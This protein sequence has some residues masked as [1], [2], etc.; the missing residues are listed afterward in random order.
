MPATGTGRRGHSECAQNKATKESA[1]SA[2]TAIHQ[3]ILVFLQLGPVVFDVPR[4]ILDVRSHDSDVSPAEVLVVNMI[5][6]IIAQHFTP[7]GKGLIRFVPIHHHPQIPSTEILESGIKFT[8][9]IGFFVMMVSLNRVHGLGGIDFFRWI[10]LND[11]HRMLQGDGKGQS[12]KNTGSS[13]LARILNLGIN[14]HRL[15]ILR[16]TITLSSHSLR[17]CA[18]RDQHLPHQAG[19][20]EQSFNQFKKALPPLAEF[21]KGTRGG[22]FEDNEFHQFG[23]HSVAGKKIKFLRLG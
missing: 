12:L 20:T 10:C 9:Q 4:T 2:N 19:I 7:P 22:F 18:I 17:S 13:I 16:R 3:D 8:V 14:F 1:S 11:G 15:A 23:I 5:G 6:P 21:G